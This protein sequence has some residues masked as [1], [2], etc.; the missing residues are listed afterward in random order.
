M[1]KDQAKGSWNEFAGKVRQKWAQMTDSDVE[2]LKGHSQEFY[3]KLQKHYGIAR[4]EAEKQIKD[5]EKTCNV[6]ASDE[7]A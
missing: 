5:M 2:L 1:N 4:D 3:G 6:C 7:A